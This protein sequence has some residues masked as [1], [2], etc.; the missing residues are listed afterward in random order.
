LLLLQE[1]EE[2]EEREKTE[3][4]KSEGRAEGCER[5]GASGGLAT[6]FFIFSLI[7]V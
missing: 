1:R 6:S 7:L 2:G 3:K 4:R 5:S